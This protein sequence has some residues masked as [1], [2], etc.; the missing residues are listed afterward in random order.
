[1]QL[2]Q[3]I[4]EAWEAEVLRSRE[5]E[6]NTLGLANFADPDEDNT[7]DPNTDVSENGSLNRGDVQENADVYVN[8]PELGTMKDSNG[9]TL[10]LDSLYG[11]L[12]NKLKGDNLIE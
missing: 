5:P 1:M 6:M 10:N 7:A 12:K 9:K 2:Q 8:D 11:D 4:K 3:L